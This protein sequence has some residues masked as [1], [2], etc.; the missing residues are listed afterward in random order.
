MRTRVALSSFLRFFLLIGLALAMVSPSGAQ[1]SV[2]LSDR[3]QRVM[4]RTEFVHANFGIEFYSLDTGRA[5]YSFNEQKLF[6]PASTT[7][8]LTEG[9]VLASLGA[10]F[11][12]HTRIYRTGPVDSKG[13]LKGDLVLV[14]SGDPNLS[15]RIQSDGTLAFTNNDHSYSGSALP[16]DPLTIIRQLAKGVAAKGIRQIEGRVL[17]DSS[18]FPETPWEAEDGGG[19]VVSSIVVNDNLVDL[20]MTPATKIGDPVVLDS[21]PQTSYVKFINHLTTAG[22][23]IAVSLNPPQIKANA[24]G[25]VIATMTG[26]LPL[27]APRTFA[28][29]L[30]LHLQS[31]RRQCCGKRLKKSAS[32]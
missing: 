6:V 12:F 21:S 11:R 7:K 22:T 14:A 18:L 3:I 20:V 32:W 29:F 19:V 31:L 16:G 13:R 5:V 9:T 25:T 28:S 24:D 4:S 2:T 30:S 8:L 1:S 26:T 10:D 17:V 23:N 27:G 15:N